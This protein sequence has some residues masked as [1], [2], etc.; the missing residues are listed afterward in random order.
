MN[1]LSKT[2]LINC[3]RGNWQSIDVPTVSSMPVTEH[4]DV[5]PAGLPLTSRKSSSSTDSS[6]CLSIHS[7]STTS[8]SDK[9]SDSVASGGGVRVA[10]LQILGSLNGSR[11]LGWFEAAHEFLFHVERQRA[12]SVYKTA[13]IAGTS[14]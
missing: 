10:G 2:I 5:F 4:Y 1:E 14:G 7:R 9:G 13:R 11:V 8:S 12:S 6:S 3:F